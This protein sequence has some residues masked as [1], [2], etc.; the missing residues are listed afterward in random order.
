MTFVLSKR[1][2]IVTGLLVLVCALGSGCNGPQTPPG[3]ID[4]SSRPPGSFVGK[5]ATPDVSPSPIAQ[6]PRL[7]LRVGE[8]KRS[9]SRAE[10]LEHPSLETITLV[11]QATYSGQSLTFRAIPLWALFEGLTVADDESLEYDTL[12]GFSSSLPATLALNRDVSKSIG[13]LAVESADEPWPTLGSGVGTAGPFYVVWKNP[14]ASSVGREQWPFQVKSFVAKPALEKRYPKILPSA[15]LPADDPVRRGFQVFVK[16][17][18]AC[19]TLNDQGTTRMG[20]DLNLPHS[21]TE[22]LKEDYFRML[23]RDPQSLRTWKASKM[24]GFPEAVLPE[25]ELDELWL[26]LS[27]MSRARAD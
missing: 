25:A 5:P 13:Y 20:P 11:D 2:V 22:Y 8:E 9:F 19:H 21:P 24:S 17:C 16:N 7:V 4:P 1:V 12:D 14:E 3:S 10:L 26:Y 15:D 6:E 18:F 23:V 27:H